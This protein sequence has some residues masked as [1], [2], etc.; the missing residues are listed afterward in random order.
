MNRSVSTLRIG[1][2]MRL[3]AA[4]VAFLAVV[5]TAVPALARTFDPQLVLSDENMRDFRSMNA[6]Q[7]QTFLNKRSGPLKRMSFAR[8]DNGAVAPASTIIW[9]ASQAWHV[10]PRVML[11]LLQKEQ[12]LL[13]RRS[14]QAHTLSRAIGAGCPDR[15]TN[16]YPGF[17]NQMWNGARMLDGYGETSKT[18]DYVPHPW[19]P[20]M[21]NRFTGGVTPKNIAT[22]KL[23]VYNPSIG[24]KRPY[25]NL[26]RQ[27]CSGNANF[28]KIYWSYFG[29]PL[30]KP[31]STP[32][33]AGVARATINLSQQS[34]RS[35]YSSPTT[36]TGYLVSADAS[37]SVAGR[38]VHLEGVSGSG[39]ATVPGSAQAVGA[40]GAF[41]FR[42]TAQRLQRV[43]VVFSG[44]SA[45]SSA[46]SGLFVRDAIPVL[47]KPGVVRSGGTAVARGS[48]APAVAITVRVTLQHKQRGRWKAWKTLSVASR[49]GAWRLR[50]KLPRGSWRARASVKDTRLAL[51]NSAWSYF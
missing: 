11:A 39:W 26:S 15:V 40:D 45:L 17:G 9:E 34:A 6:A 47:S 33:P 48:I 23:Y 49:G 18:T 22:Y 4:G 29:N 37:V 12:S 30:G 10:N 16:R 25:G 43:R 19:K 3:I 50:V 35:L 8:H 5:G 38:P 14:L 46:A 13:T 51:A 42:L 44:G 41:A 28:W 7:I 31:K 24:A 27:S 1:R 2:V 36:L 32:L 21:K 20:G